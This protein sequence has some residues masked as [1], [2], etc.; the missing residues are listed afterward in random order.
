MSLLSSG[1]WCDLCQ[2][3]IIDDPYWHIAVQ[4]KKGYSC[5]KCKK[6]IE[7]HGTDKE[8]EEKEFK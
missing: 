3:P 1:L 2:K 8:I 4:N 6:E 5:D 7:N